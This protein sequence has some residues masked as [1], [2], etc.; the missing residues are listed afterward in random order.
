M[1]RN[2]LYTVP[3]VVGYIDDTPEDIDSWFLDDSREQLKYK[4]TYSSLKELV[5]ETVTIF[6]E[7][8]PDFR[9]LFG[10]YGSG[11]M[12]DN[13]GDTTVCKLRKVIRQNED[14]REIEFCLNN[15]NFKIMQFCIYANSSKVATSF[16]DALVEDYSFQYIN[17]RLER[18]VGGSVISIKFV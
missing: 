12:E 8:S 15:D 4:M 2:F 10:L 17:E 6:E 5:N 9:K 13:R 3:T 1:N 7:G 11:L 16:R 14:I 18:E